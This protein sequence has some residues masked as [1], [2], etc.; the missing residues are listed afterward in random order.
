MKIVIITEC[1]RKHRMSAYLTKRFVEGATDYPQ[2][3]Y[4]LGKSLS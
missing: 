3:A 1:A 4:E 2:K